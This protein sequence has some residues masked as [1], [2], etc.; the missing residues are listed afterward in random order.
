M[1]VQSGASEVAVTVR[2]FGTEEI[3]IGTV[4]AGSAATVRL[5]GLDSTRGWQVTARGACISTMG[6]GATVR[7]AP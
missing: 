1:F 4:P 2:R 3:R 7:P 6:A 5:Y